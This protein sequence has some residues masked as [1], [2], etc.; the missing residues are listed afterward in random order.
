LD[1]YWDKLS[2]YPR[3]R[4]LRYAQDKLSGPEANYRSLAEVL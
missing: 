1:Y 3:H 2:A 4:F